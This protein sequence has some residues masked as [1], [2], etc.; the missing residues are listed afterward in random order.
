[1]DNREGIPGGRVALPAPLEALRKRLSEKIGLSVIVRAVKTDDPRFRGRLSQNPRRLL[2]EIQ[3]SQH[4][5][6]WDYD[7]IEE[8][9]AL[10]AQGIREI[11][12]M[13]E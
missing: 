11:N 9:F 2:V 4:G 1:M 13:E 6:F 8:L 5:Y 12:V 7:I 10:A 3:T